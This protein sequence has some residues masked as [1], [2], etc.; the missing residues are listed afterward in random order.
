MKHPSI[1]LYALIAL[2]P[3]LWLSCG[4]GRNSSRFDLKRAEAFMNSY[5]AA[6]RSGDTTQIHNHWSRSSLERV[7]FETMHLWV[8]ATI[9]ITQWA[10][11]LEDSRMTYR[12][13]QVT[14]ED[15]Y[16]VIEFDWVPHE[17][18]SGPSQSTSHEMRYYVILEEGRWVLGNPIDVL[19]RSWKRHEVEHLIFYCPAEI[20]I[21]MHL[22]EIHLVD[23]RCSTML[24]AL[25]LEMEQ[26]IEYYKAESPRQCGELVSY[27]PANGYAAI[28]LTSDPDV[29]SWFDLV[30]SI[31]FD[32][33][34]E[35]MHVLASKAGIPYVSAAFCEGLAVAFGGTTFQAPELAPV[36][37]KTLIGGPAYV[38]LITLLTMPDADFLRASYITYQEAGAF[39][40]YLLDTFGVARVRD[41]CDDIVATGDVNEAARETYGCPLDSLETLLHAYLDGVE[42]LDVGAAIPAGAQPVFSMGDPAGDDRGDG[43]YAYPADDR[44]CEGAFDLREFTV[45]RDSSRVYF[46]LSLDDVIEPA[47]YTDG[48][49]RF[50]P[51][52]VI[53]IKKGGGSRGHLTRSCHGIQFKEGDGFDV[54]LAVGFGVCIT[55]S[56]GKVISTTGDIS[57]RLLKV[58]DDAMEFSVPL[59]LIGEP[60]DTWSY[61]V[62]IGLMSDRAMDFFGGPLPAVMTSDI[63]I[64]G[65]NARHGNPAFIDIL[66]PSDIDQNSLLGAYDGASGRLAVVPMI[67]PGS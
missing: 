11:F 38:P 1:Y 55:D 67:E 50:V 23:A 36:K 7:G 43:D 61:F 35:V 56:F 24:E 19:T 16:H 4:T 6:L 27:P 13:R 14:S 49:E 33:A 44:F 34:H 37:T 32:N 66:L 12:I 41:F 48:G 28:Q 51:G 21:D 2:L 30:V 52:G 39:V 3:A 62:G 18:T 40:R 47:S 57:D 60:D 65:G 26:K 46:R 5:V 9:H 10:E 58:S 54:K 64:S 59:S 22:D 25:D 17:D 53:A 63:L 8:G 31:R 45:L 15:D 42:S 29:P 20:D